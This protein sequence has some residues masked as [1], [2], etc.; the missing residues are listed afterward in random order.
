MDNDIRRRNIRGSKALKLG[1]IYSIWNRIH[2]K[3][4]ADMPYLPVQENGE[5]LQGRLIIYRSDCA[6]Q[7]FPLQHQHRGRFIASL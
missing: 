6:N 3:R 7:T 1:I 2:A 5:E 4:S